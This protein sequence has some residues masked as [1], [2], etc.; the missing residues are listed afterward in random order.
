MNKTKIMRFFQKLSKAFLTPLA[1][2]AAASLAM[3]IASFFTSGDVLNY[4]P[5]LNHWLIQYIFQ[6]VLKMG[7]IITGNFGALY[8][9]ALAFALSDENKEVAAFSGF[10]GYLA[11]LTG[12]GM[13]ITNFPNVAEMFPGNGITSVLGIETVN[14]GMLGGIFVG[15]FTSWIHKK[16]KDVR[17]PMAFSFFSGLKLVP[18]MSLA[19]F[20]IIG[21]FIP[22]IWVY[23]SRGIALLASGLNQLGLFGP[24]VYGFIERLLIPTGLHQV[25]ISIV[26][27]TSVSGIYEFASGAII[28]GQRPAFMQFLAEGLPLNASLADLVKFSYGPQ[29]PIMLGALPAIGLAIYHCADDDKKQNIKPLILSAVV[30]AMIAG[31]SE[32][33]EFIFL[34]TAPLLYV[35]YAILYG[36]SWVIMNVLGSQ[37][38]YGSGI[39]EFVIFGILRSDS[40]WWICVL[41]ILIEFAMNYALFRWAIMKFNIKTPGRGSEIDETIEENEDTEIKEEL[42][43]NPKVVRAR[44]IIKGLGGKENIVEVDAC[45][46]RLRVIVKDNGLIDEE[47]IKK[48]NCSGIIKPSA[49]DIQIVYGTMVNLIKDAVEKELKK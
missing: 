40:R 29:I 3:G 27:D 46:S 26:R 19:I 28:E 17:L 39:I 8:A 37:I 24:F 15:I 1:L 38:G 11:L 47:L 13:I 43:L 48:T 12:M 7:S 14:T 31:I 25:W 41:V 6:V 20:M 34:F 36:L 9:V 5:F 18:I 10:V 42:T 22:F 33:L 45:M 16:F 35:G 23:I 21:N 44:N 49:N 2:I 4:L 32:P 30:T